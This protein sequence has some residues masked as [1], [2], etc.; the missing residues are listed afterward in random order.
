M[1]RFQDVLFF[2][3]SAPRCIEKGSRASARPKCVATDAC[4]SLTLP[5]YFDSPHD[6]CQ[7]YIPRHQAQ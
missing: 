5:Q 3:S 4:P 1:V 6:V 2:H 7:V